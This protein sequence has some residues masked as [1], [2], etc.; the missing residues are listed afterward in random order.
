MSMLLLV[1]ENSYRPP[2]QFKTEFGL[3]ALVCECVYVGAHGCVNVHSCV[4]TNVCTHMLW[5]YIWEPED[6]L[7]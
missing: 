7:Q 1:P 3:S 5:M 2:L 6:N 4:H